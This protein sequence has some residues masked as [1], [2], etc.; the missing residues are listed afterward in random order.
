MEQIEVRNVTFKYKGSKKPSLKNIDLKVKRGDFVL[1]IGPTGCGKT[2]LLRTMNGLIPHFYEGDMTG[3][4]YVE[5]VNTKDVKTSELAQKVGLV[6]QNPDNQFITLNV[7]REISFGLENLGLAEE[8]IRGIVRETIKEFNLE[9]IK[10]KPPYALSGGEK[11]KVIIAAILAMNPDILVLD[12]PTANLDPFNARKIID[13]L[14]IINKEKGKTIIL[15]E[16]RTYYAAR[17]ANRV[18]VM[19]KGEKISEGS[20]REVFLKEIIEEVGVFVPFPVKLYKFLTLNW[21]PISTV[22]LTAEETFKLL[23]GSN[24]AGK[25]YPSHKFTF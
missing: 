19:S 10:D 20:P 24:D 25:S 13:L 8:E 17:Y 7:E 5:G 21:K 2:T 3:D 6:F 14:H 18:V 11:Q 22:P 9:K 16:H 23:R 4:V 15:V 12:E 1:I